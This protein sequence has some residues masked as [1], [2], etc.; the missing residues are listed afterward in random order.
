MIEIPQ[1][2][3]NWVLT[4]CGATLGWIVKTVWG[5]QQ[6][7]NND[8]TD[9]RMRLAENYVTNHRLEQFQTALFAKLDRIEDKIDGKVDK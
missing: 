1:W 5:A 4:G 9:L 6:K 8:L 7:L 3:I 2:L